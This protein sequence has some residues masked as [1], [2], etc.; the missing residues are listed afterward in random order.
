MNKKILFVSYVFPPTGG[1]GIQRTV[2]LVKYF[3]KLGWE[4]FIL[5]AKNPS[6]PVHDYEMLKD[7]HPGIRIFK[8][9]S[10]EIPYA[11]KRR[12]W[13]GAV[14]SSDSKA[15]QAIGRPKPASIKSKIIGSLKFLVHLIMLPD[16]QIGWNYFTAK[17]AGRIIKKHGI[18]YVF[19]SAPPFSSLLLTDKLSAPGVKIVADFR[20]EW[21]EFYLKSYD[22][23]QRD[24]FTTQ[25]IIG[26]EKSV[27]ES[28]DLITMATESF[29]NNYRNK[30]PAHSSKIRLLTNG[31]D[32]DDFKGQHQIKQ[33]QKTFNIT[34]TGTIF[35][36]TT[37]R[38]LL[39]AMN[40]VLSDRDDLKKS[41]KLNF[42]GRITDDEKNYFEDFKF[43]EQ[44]NLPGYV[45]HNE[46]ISYLYSSDLLVVIVDDLEGSDRIIAAKVFEYINTGIPILAL[47]P[48]KGEIA[49]IVN[50][51]RAGLVI[52]NRD[53]DRIKS[54]LIKLIN[55]EY[56]FDRNETEIARYSRENIARQ[57]MDYLTEL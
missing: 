21:T 18:G 6:V 49:R 33:D 19:I 47:V 45:S 26:M 34:Y 22:F 30:Y 37:A 50:N 11:L 14:K 54:A 20:D 25:K 2:K 43:P 52:S 38:F 12:L 32:P 23:H 17:K 16:P 41:V 10:L 8:S 3:H 39:E 53:T 7:I 51:T 13:S 5:T 57:L 4:P 1:A 36:V 9:F 24:E 28:C 56:T 44:L 55:K 29:V 27:I 15:D 35:N 48:E 40:E 46:S 31:F 42:V